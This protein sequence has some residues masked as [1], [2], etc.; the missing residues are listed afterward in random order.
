MNVDLDPKKGVTSFSVGRATVHVYASKQTMGVA[1]ANEAAGIINSAVQ[2]FGSA[3]IMVATGNSQLD[4][5]SQLVR[6]PGIDW[7]SVEIFHMDEYVGLPASHPSSFQY[8]IKTRIEDVV[9]PAHVHYINAEARHFDREIA[10]YT[11]LLTS[12][13]IHLAFVGFGENGHIAFNDP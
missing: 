1:S 7:R 8:W 12:A 9:H 4:L 5:V 2:R 13:P 6:Q 3:R 10:R 11:A